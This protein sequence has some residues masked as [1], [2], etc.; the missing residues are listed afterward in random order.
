MRKR[1]PRLDRTVAEAIASLLETEFNDPRLVMVS[2]TEAQVS[3]DA[4]E[5]I[6]FW[7]VPDNDLLTD[8]PRHRRAGDELPR[9]DE[10]AAALD[11]A[12]PR[13]QKLLARSVKLRNTPVLRF[14]QDPVRQA[15]DRVE[16]LLRNIDRG[17]A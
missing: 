15:A 13:L 8:D 11:S 10:A 14:E 9:P 7:S 1:N 3:Q 12:R 4:K 5:A 17:D 2:I 6:V 16:Q